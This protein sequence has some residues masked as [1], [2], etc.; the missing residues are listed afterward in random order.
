[1]ILLISRSKFE[2][3]VRKVILISIVSLL[4]STSVNSRRE[5][6]MLYSRLTILILLFTISIC[7]DILSFKF[8]SKGIGI[9]GGLLH[10]NSV[11]IVFDLFICIL[12]VCILTLTSFKPHKILLDIKEINLKIN[13]LNKLINLS[14]QFRI[15]EYPLIILFIVLGAILLMSSNDL[16]TMFLSIEL[17]SYG[18]YLLSTLYRNSELSTSGGLTYFLLGGLSSCLILLSTC[19]IYANSGTTSLDSLYLITNISETYPSRIYLFYQPNYIQYSLIIMGVGFLF[20]VSAAPFHFWSPDVYDSIPTVVTTFVAIMAKISIFILLLDIVNSTWKSLFYLNY[21]WI[22][23]LLLSSILSLLIGSILGLTQ[24][25]IKR[26]YAYSTISHVGFILLSLS[27]CSVESIQGFLFYLIQYSLSN[28]NA[29]I[30][31]LTIGYSLFFYT[32]DK[33]KFITEKNNSPVQLI[34]QIKGYY[35]INPFLSLSLS[36]SLFSFAGVPPLVGFFAKQ[37]VFSS[38]LDNG[39][40]FITLIAILTSVISA[41]YYLAVIKIM[42]FEKP[43]YKYKL[44]QEFVEQIVSLNLSSEII[45]GS[46]TGNVEKNKSIKDQKENISTPEPAN[47]VFNLPNDNKVLQD[48]YIEYPSNLNSLDSKNNKYLQ[49]LIYSTIS[50]TKLA[51]HLSII[52]SILTLFILLFIFFPEEWLC[53]CKLLSLTIIKI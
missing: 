19:L 25:R 46:K 30:I 1:M 13:L 12:S 34:K 52:I 21:T 44:E 41:A 31:L 33:D 7:Y 39:Y 3:W 5:K 50:N 32:N 38:A 40:V 20:K 35:Y 4:V 6:S 10:V 16:V 27:V 42:F 49:S 23:S 36:I 17:Q 45:L 48:V 43:Y 28:L 2:S 53:M 29:F 11:T 14:E 22:N 26:L 18:L 47:L 37:N 15:I 24:F 51:S 8:L 9:Y